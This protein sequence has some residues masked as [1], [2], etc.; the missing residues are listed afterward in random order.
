MKEGYA[1]WSQSNLN[2]NFVT[3]MLKVKAAL[4]PDCVT[5]HVSWKELAIL[6]ALDLICCNFLKV[7]QGPSQFENLVL[8]HFCTLLT[9]PIIK[10]T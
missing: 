5:F 6:Y 8:L 3:V 10:I 1:I 7:Y 4:G 9:A 2:F